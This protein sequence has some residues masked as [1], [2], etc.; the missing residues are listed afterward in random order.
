MANLITTRDIWIREMEKARSGNK[1]I[2]ERS[3]VIDDTLYQSYMDTKGGHIGHI[4]FDLVSNDYARYV[5]H[6]PDPVHHD[7]DRGR[8]TFH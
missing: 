4:E 8:R 7:I 5:I 2:V 3:F 1:R 6:M